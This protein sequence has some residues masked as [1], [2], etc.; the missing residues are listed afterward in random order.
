MTVR[1]DLYRLVDE[2][3]SDNPA[4]ALRAYRQMDEY[5]MGWLEQRVVS[6][7]RR[8]G[9]TW[10]E[11]AR[12][13]HRSRQSVHTKFRTM[14]PTIHEGADEPARRT[15]LEFLRLYDP[16]AGRVK[17]DPYANDDSPVAW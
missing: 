1:T 8:N 6:V 11:I 3:L 2:L 4:D 13:L 5:E 17:V 7:A 16:V 14:M 9:W 10:G 12:Y 15:E